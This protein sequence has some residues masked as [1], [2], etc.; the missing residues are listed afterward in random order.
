MGNLQYKLVENDK[1]LKEALYI[2][3]KVFV[4]EQGISDTLDRDGNDSLA[5][6]VLVTKEDHTIGT[7]RIRF[8][9]NQQAKLERM[10]ILKPSRRVGIGRGVIS[11]LEKE[12]KKRGV[13]RIVL[14]AQYPA[15]DFYKNCGF[16]ETG[17]PFLEAGIRHNRMEKDI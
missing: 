4:E 16:E 8:L 7:V 1:E 2:R 10:A 17:L 9:D 12:L 3:K 15:I 13:G 6:H 14:H 5:F 11:F